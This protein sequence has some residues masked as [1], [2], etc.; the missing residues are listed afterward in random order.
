MKVKKSVLM[1]VMASCVSGFTLTSCGTLFTSS[2]QAIMFTGENGATIYDKGKV[3]ARTDDDGIAT[4]KVRKS[5]SDKTLVVKKE[6]YK[7]TPVELEAVFN[8]VS[9]LNLGNLFGWGID[10]A[11]GKCCKWDTDV[12]EF[13]MEKK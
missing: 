7:N 10:L 6:G 4:A 2:H 8:P 5:L 1:L 12:V 9:I 11:T 13:E 3:L